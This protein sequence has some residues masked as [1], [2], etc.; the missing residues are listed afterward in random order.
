MAIWDEIKRG[1]QSSVDSVQK[2]GKAAK[3]KAAV[4]NLEATLG[5]RI[6]D[7]GTRVLELHR[8]NDL[9]HVELD[10][11]FVDIQ[12]LQRELREREAELGTLVGK[13]APVKADSAVCPDCGAKA[14]GTD[15]F[16]R[17]CGVDLRGG[18]DGR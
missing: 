7:L 2:L 14:L 4:R 10:Q 11:L 12:T 6:Y 8:R 15:R 5:D 3:L 16:C 13:P 17:H 1:A 9:H 18:G